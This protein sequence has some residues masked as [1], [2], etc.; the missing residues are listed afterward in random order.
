MF[1]R[2]ERWKRQWKKKEGEE[3]MLN[4]S[5]W[6]KERIE[7]KEEKR[8][9]EEKCRG[10]FLFALRVNPFPTLEVITARYIVGSARGTINRL[11]RSFF[12][13]SPFAQSSSPPFASTE[14]KI[15]KKKKKGRKGEFT[16]WISDPIV[17]RARGQI[18]LVVLRGT[19]LRLSRFRARRDSNSSDRSIYFS[20]F[21]AR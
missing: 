3:V 19:R 12:S 15:F 7:G 10:S 14:E 1:L 4:W 11:Q 2:R 5:R 9:G 13:P 16:R 21:A 17:G 18:S 6:E 20:R 8:K